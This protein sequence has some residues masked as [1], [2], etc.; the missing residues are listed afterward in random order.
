[1]ANCDNSDNKKTIPDNLCVCCYPPDFS[2]Y[3]LGNDSIPDDAHSDIRRRGINEYIVQE[4]KLCRLK[5]ILSDENLYII[6]IDPRVENNKISKIIIERNPFTGK[7]L[8]RIEYPHKYKKY[9]ICSTCANLP[10]LT[11]KIRDIFDI[12]LSYIGRQETEV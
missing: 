9:K 6:H 2:P 8:R 11:A 1:M 7:I 5:K 12:P 4:L 10:D 3:K